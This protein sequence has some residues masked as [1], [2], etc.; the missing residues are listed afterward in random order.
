MNT[1]VINK[2][3]EE[4]N[5]VSKERKTLKKAKIA[6]YQEILKE[7]QDCRALGIQW[8]I[9]KFW[10]LGE[11]VA[12]SMLPDFLDAKAKDFILFV[13]LELTEI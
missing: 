4:I 12:T 11:V 9:R 2:I 1:K 7:G 10:D 6:L 8:L 5:N 13:R 3:E